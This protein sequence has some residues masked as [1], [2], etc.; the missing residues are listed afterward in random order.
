MYAN[1]VPDCILVHPVVFMCDKVPRAPN[2]LPVDF[3][4]GI[5]DVLR[6]TICGLAHAQDIE[7][8]HV[9]YD[10]T[11]SKLHTIQSGGLGEQSLAEPDHVPA[12]ECANPGPAV[13]NR[14]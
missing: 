12:R 7:L 2:A 6:D 3:R 14:P 11:F 13:R 8:R 5:A 4:M 10:R 9:V 1:N